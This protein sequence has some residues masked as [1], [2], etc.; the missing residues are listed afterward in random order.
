MIKLFLAFKPESDY[1]IFIVRED[2]ELTF[3]SM[4][5]FQVLSF[6]LCFEILYYPKCKSIYLV[7]IVKLF[8]IVWVK[9]RH[10]SYK[11]GAR[12]VL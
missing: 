4:D 11:M 6:S 3:T 8:V 9:C 2:L 12:F 1:N 5:S 10:G 7:W